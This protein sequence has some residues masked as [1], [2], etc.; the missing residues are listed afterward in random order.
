[1]L[2]RI[3]ECVP[4]FSEGRRPQV[5][6]AIVDA[7]RSAPDVYVLDVS[8]D[9][10][11]N[12]TVVTFVGSPESVDEGAFRGIAVAKERINLD[13][14]QG[15]HPRIGATDV[16]PF[17][18]VRN[19]TMEECVAIARRLGQRVGQEL[20]IPVYLYGEAATRPER[21]R[22]AH[23][24]RGQYERWKE[25]IGRVPERDP[26]FGPPVAG[27]WGA[28]VIG[29]RPFLIAYNL[30]L[31]SDDVAI[32]DRIARHVRHSSGGLRFVQAKGFL[33]E[34]Q[35]QVSMNLTHF[36]KTPIPM[37][38]ELVKR[39]AAQW[40]LAVT[41]AELVG[42]IP[43]KALTD[44][45]KWYLQLHDLEDDQ[46]L[47]NKLASVLEEAER[48]EP[49]RAALAPRAFLEAVAA[50]TPTPG[51]G[52]TAALAAALAAALT[53]M[54]AGLTLGRKRYAGVQ[55]RAQKAL[56]RAREL[57]ERL[58][59]AVQ[60]DA[61]AFDALMAAYRDKEA[62][63]ETRRRAIQAATRRAGEVPLEV[64]RLALEVAQLALE[65]A[66][67]GNVNAR[68]DAGVGALMAQAGVRGAGLNVRVNAREL[69]DT[70]LAQAW[71]QEVQELEERVQ[72]L[73]EEAVALARA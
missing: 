60:E 5:I 1:M 29:A 64:A 54:V 63:P 55:D 22:L 56:D 9:P 7:I 2:N 33:V 18:P 43:Q 57:R 59:R 34:G 17:V 30:Y 61:D 51:G 27:P 23:I 67:V 19:V 50:P 32:A 73:V 37:V 45:A 46:I 36:E 68:S 39:D 53:E 24:R 49:A 58:A 42:M 25:E 66:R 40:G 70:A 10:D 13:E 69:E 11:H 8:S 62:D 20:G 28:T 3:V 38:Q 41:R 14:H 31:N 44:A 12:R 71:E 16:V 21:Q 65:M 4:N 52:S 15:E 72:A 26:D 6:Q 47:E 35:A 48:T